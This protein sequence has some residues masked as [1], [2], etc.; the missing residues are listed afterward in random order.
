[1][2]L[3]MIAARIFLVG[4]LVIPIAACSFSSQSGSTASNPTSET[5]SIENS[6]RL[7]SGEFLLVEVDDEYRP[8]AN[9]VPLQT[10]YSFDESGSFKRQNKTRLEEGVYLISTQSELVIYVEK[11]NGELLTEAHV[12]RY[13]IIEESSDSITLGNGP[14][15]KL[16]LK[17]R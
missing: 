16:V 12:D 9:P 1:M 17:K 7:L 13:S 3:W 6:G 15:R 14:S 10:S 11:I 2:R 4:T 5:P 8:K